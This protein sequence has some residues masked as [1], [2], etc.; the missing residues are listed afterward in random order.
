M[1][2]TATPIFIQAPRLGQGTVSAANTIWGNSPNNVATVFT[3]GANGSA[4]SKISVILRE[5]STQGVAQIYASIDGG[6]TK[7][8]IDS[9]GVSS[10]TITTSAAATRYDSTIASETAPYRLP[11]S[12]VVY[13]GYTVGMTSAG[14]ACNITGGDY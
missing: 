14:V 9:I 6:T 2:V 3:A 11:A 4:L 5:S 8:L 13:F 7:I 10:A 1:P 12:A